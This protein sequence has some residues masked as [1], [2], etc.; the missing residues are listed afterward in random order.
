MT[1]YVKSVKTLF[2][3]GPGNSTFIQLL[4]THISCFTLSNYFSKVQDFAILLSYYN[5]QFVRYDIDNVDN[6]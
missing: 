5:H 4:L 2:P 6:C 3:S 1:M